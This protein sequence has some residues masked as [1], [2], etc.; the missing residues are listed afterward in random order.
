METG[1]LVGGRHADS[2]DVLSA[3]QRY[4]N[5]AEMQL[6]PQS[7]EDLLALLQ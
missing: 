7:A 1:Q 5:V 2:H 4:S 6:V 3:Y